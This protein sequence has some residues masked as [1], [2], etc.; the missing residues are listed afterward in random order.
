MLRL[1]RR[2]ATCAG[3]APPRSTS[4]GPPRALRRLLRARAEPWDVAAGALVCARAGLAVWR[5]GA[6]P[7]PA[8]MLVAPPA[9]AARWPADRLMVGCPAPWVTPAQPLVQGGAS[10]HCRSHRLLRAAHPR[11]PVPAAL[12]ASRARRPEGRRPAA[13][14]P[15]RPPARWAGSKPFDSPRRRCARAAAPA[16]RAAASRRLG[17]SRP[18]ASGEAAVRRLVPREEEHAPG[19]GEIRVAEVVGQQVVERGVH[20][21]APVAAER[22]AP[23]R[24]A[25]QASWSSIPY[26][27]A[28]RAAGSRAL[29][30]RNPAKPT[31]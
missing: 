28:R 10:D 6:P 4:Y 21:L 20:V 3:S 1:L 29:S 22:L 12:A 18:R 9:L 2:C 16:A 8:G 31:G 27:P 30:A 26:R 5:S 15:A 7:C 11:V 14:P 17:R 13:A 19:A 25:L 23:V 24:V